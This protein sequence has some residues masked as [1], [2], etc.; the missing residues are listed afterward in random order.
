MSLASETHRWFFY[1]PENLP[2]PSE[3][4]PI[5]IKK[6]K[7]SQKFSFNI[8]YGGSDKGL[9]VEVQFDASSNTLKGKYE[10]QEPFKMT[11]NVSF[12][13]LNNGTR[14]EGFPDGFCS[15][16]QWIILRDDYSTASSQGKSSNSTEFI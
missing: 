16:C 1:Y 11:N 9:R 3:S 13:V 7:G 4:I 10:V 6:E 5:E 2:L 15:L 14:L 12:Q 8:P